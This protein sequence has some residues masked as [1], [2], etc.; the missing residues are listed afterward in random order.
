MYNSTK[1]RAQ[2]VR[3]LVAQHYEPGRQDRC[4][5][6]VWRTIVRPRYGISLRTFYAYLREGGDRRPDGDDRQ[7]TLF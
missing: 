2:E 6:W 7:L 1:L 3:R 5:A 4:K